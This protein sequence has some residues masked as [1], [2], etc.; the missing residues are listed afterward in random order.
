M[1]DLGAVG[2]LGH[3][4]L[5]EC[6]DDSDGSLKFLGVAELGR[7]FG[8][9]SLVAAL[10]VAE[11]AVFTAESGQPRLQRVHLACGCG[12]SGLDCSN[13]SRMPSAG[14]RP[15]TVEFSSGSL[16]SRR[17]GFVLVPKLTDLRGDPFEFAATVGGSRTEPAFEL[18]A[19][20]VQRVDR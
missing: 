11:G 16:G 19:F 1:D 13:S 8:G 18:D 15:E 4:S 12:S 17:G 7:V 20:C 5:V 6:F 10:L 2:A 9:P 3:G 14:D